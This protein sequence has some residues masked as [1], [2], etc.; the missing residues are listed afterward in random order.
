MKEQRIEVTVDKKGNAKV[1]AFGFE[2]GACL[3][4]TEDLEQV[5]GKVE[6]REMKAEAARQPQTGHKVTVGGKK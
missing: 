6:K 3:K 4:E 1:E 5:L 2:G